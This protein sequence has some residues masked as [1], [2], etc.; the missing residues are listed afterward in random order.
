MFKVRHSFIGPAVYS[1]PDV[2][3][4][5]AEVAQVGRIQVAEVPDFVYKYSIPRKLTN[6][7]KKLV[8]KPIY[9]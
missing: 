6:F 1:T 4:G 7:R 5:S 8:K 9:I 2:Y 3:F